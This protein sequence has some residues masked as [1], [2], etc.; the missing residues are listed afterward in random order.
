M[1]SP[2]EEIKSKLDIVDV[3]SEYVPLKQAGVNFKACCPFHEEKTPSFMVNREKQFFHC[4][5][6]NESGDVF[7]FIQKMENIEFPEALKI[8]ANKAG[9]EL[10]EYNPRMSNLKTRL[11]D[12]QLAAARWFFAQLKN[13]EAGKTAYNYLKEKRGLTDETITEWKLGYALDSWENLS[14]YL[15]SKKFTREEIIQGGLVVQKNSSQDFYDRFRDRVMFPIAD[16]HGNIVGFTGRT[17]KADEQAKYVNSPQTPIYNKSEVIFGLDKAKSE[18][19]AQDRVVVVEGNMDVISSH[20]AGVTNVVAVSG[21]ALTEEQIRI[22]QRLTNNFVFSFDTDAAGMRAAERSI[23]LA[24]QK[25]VSVRVAVIRDEESKDPDDLV[26]KDVKLWQQAIDEAPLAMDYFFEMSW[27]DYNPNDV[28]S[29]KKAASELLGYIARLGNAIERDVYL[30][31]LAEALE[32]SE[33]SLRQAIKKY[34]NQ[35]DRQKVYNDKRTEAAKNDSQRAVGTRDEAV[36]KRARRLLEAGFLG[37]EYMDFIQEKLDINYLPQDLG[38]VYK[39]MIVYYTKQY[40][41]ESGEMSLLDFLLASGLANGEVRALWM[42]AEEKKSLGHKDIMADVR[43]D[44][45]E[46]KK[47]F[48]RSKLSE[49]E[50]RQRELERGAEARPGEEDD[51]SAKT[52]EWQRALGEVEE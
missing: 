38:Q 45:V 11:I 7:T 17:M 43:S 30:K 48:I 21:T 44:M 5:G 32:V 27:R 51:L 14:K 6:C 46:L 41:K 9:V 2:T 47:T 1:F 29:K 36:A 22:L 34:F 8:L 39:L 10:P 33:E 31:R 40:N 42:A 16:Y 24:W 3:I 4:F 37:K 35:A 49:I 13:S 23:A 12:M 28:E 50:K 52:V 19:K 18:I 20:Q 26:R 15:L 25:E